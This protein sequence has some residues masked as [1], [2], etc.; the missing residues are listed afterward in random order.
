V[1]QIEDLT[2]SL[3]RKAWQKIMLNNAMDDDEAE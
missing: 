3:S 2:A 1:D